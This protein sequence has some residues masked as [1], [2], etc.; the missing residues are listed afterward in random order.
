MKSEEK[1][2]NFLAYL[3]EKYTI[4]FRVHYNLHHVLV[5]LKSVELKLKVDQFCVEI[6]HN[7]LGNL[8]RLFISTNIKQINVG[9]IVYMPNFSE[10]KQPS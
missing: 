2:E 3:S 6:I 8:C 5:Q 10:S 7:F 9:Y 4:V 1:G